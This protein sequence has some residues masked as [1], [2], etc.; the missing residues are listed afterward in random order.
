MNTED[1][2][3]GS[4]DVIQH[5]IALVNFVITKVDFF[6]P[7][8]ETDLPDSEVGMSHKVAFEDG[9]DRAFMVLIQLRLKSVQESDFRLNVDAVALFNTNKPIDE[10]FKQ[11]PLAN[12]NAVAI[13]F[14][15]LR[16]FL[17]SFTVNAGVPRLI[18]P[19]VNFHKVSKVTSEH[20]KKSAGGEEP[21]S[22]NP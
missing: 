2:R 20:T 22:P 15:F 16:S 21:S 7:P 14:P 8:G 10:Q 3:Q 19:S 13:A 4:E 5:A 9:L 17:A 11:S 12:V 6:V 1:S 18:L